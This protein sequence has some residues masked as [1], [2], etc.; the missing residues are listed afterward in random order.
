MTPSRNQPCPCGSGKK[1]K[2]CCAKQ[3]LVHPAAT[4]VTMPDGTKMPIPVALQTA[5]QL[6]QAGRLRK[7]GEIYR[8]LL[9]LQPQHVDAMHLL[10]V[11]EHQLGNY[12]QAVKLIQQAIQIS[13]NVGMFHNNLGKALFALGRLDE[14]VDKYRNALSLQANSPEACYNLGEALRAQNRLDE[15]EAQ[16]IQALALN[17]AYAEA[18]FALG[19]VKQ[20]QRNF[21]KAGE[22]YAKALAIR[23]D[24]A[25]L[26]NIVAVGLRLQG[27]LDDAL[28]HCQRAISLK[29]EQAEFYSNFAHVLKGQG[30][31]TD[32]ALALEK[33]LTLKPDDE[34]CRH[35]LAAMRNETTERAPAGYVRD[36]FDRY[37]ENFDA[38]L[39]NKLEYRTPEQLAELIVAHLRPSVG[40]LNVLDMGCGTGLFGVCIKPYARRLV[41]VDLSPRM[42]D[43]ADKRAIYDELVVADVLEW[44][45]QQEAASFDLL[46]ATDV[47]IYLGNLTPV[48]EQARRILRG[49]GILA[50]S[51][52][53]GADP[54]KDYYLT[55]TGRYQQT[56]AY[57][58][59]LAQAQGFS[60]VE[61]Q[62]VVIRKEQDA[63]VQGELYL[64]M[65]E[66]VVQVGSRC[67]NTGADIR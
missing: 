55:S 3:A 26:H 1:F 63:P 61:S 24:D 35:L 33:V 37:A 56:P 65:L 50:F 59:R 5:M 21:E 39:V 29:P 64:F 20:A 34:T 47:F 2:H 13:P 62:S 49:G 25:F 8:R 54:D 40:A 22:W 12:P 31:L 41:G 51:I 38:H 4:A 60:E 44:L 30:K 45:G 58:R 52:E 32:S 9:D 10:G 27:R 53:I 19:A 46:A 66:P 67:V 16:L 48:F 42:I 57:I 11:V 23:P 17:P 18:C 6:H 14:A 28:A 43:Q 15:A 7:A 36:T